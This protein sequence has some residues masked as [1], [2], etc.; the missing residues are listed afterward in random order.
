MPPL[1]RILCTHLK[2][3]SIPSGEVTAVP[4]IQYKRAT[5]EG[6][7]QRVWAM[8][9]DQHVDGEA[10]K[11]IFRKYIEQYGSFLMYNFF[12]KKRF[13]GGRSSSFQQR[14]LAHKLSTLFLILLPYWYDFLS[15]GKYNQARGNFIANPPLRPYSFESS[16]K[17]YWTSVTSRCKKSKFATGIESL[18]SIEQHCFWKF[19]FKLET[20]MKKRYYMKKYRNV[21]TNFSLLKYPNKWI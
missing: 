10:R 20:T 1:Q 17:I 7:S 18:P 19:N 4:P 12:K 8:I 13:G 11:F 21:K 5:S 9:K 15:I 16:I 14:S 3:C 6:D 2:L